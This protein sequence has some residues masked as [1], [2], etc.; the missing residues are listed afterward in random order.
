LKVL[1]LA[2]ADSVKHAPPFDYA[3]SEPQ[4]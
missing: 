1:G 3:A 4:R 2:D